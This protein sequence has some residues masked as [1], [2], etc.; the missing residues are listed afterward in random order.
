MVVQGLITPPPPF[1]F[2]LSKPLFPTMS[3][4]LVHHWPHNEKSSRSWCPYLPFWSFHL[5]RAIVYLL[6]RKLRLLICQNGAYIGQIFL[7]ISGPRLITLMCCNT[8]SL[9]FFTIFYQ[10]ILLKVGR[11]RK[12]E[13][14][15]WIYKAFWELF[16]R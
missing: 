14:K 13:V 11:K 5:W 15:D 12:E 7:L 6:L 10:R 2:P 16:N 8:N 9:C 1:I 3:T 4:L